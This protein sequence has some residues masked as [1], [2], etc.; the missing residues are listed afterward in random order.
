MEHKSDS[1]DNELVSLSTHIIFMQNV[2]FQ[3]KGK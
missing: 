2:K 3:N 1:S